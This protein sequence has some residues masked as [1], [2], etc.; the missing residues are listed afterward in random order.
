MTSRRHSLVTARVTPGGMRSHH[1]ADNMDETF[2]D[3]FIRNGG[4]KKMILIH[5]CTIFKR[6]ELVAIGQVWSDFEFATKPDH[7]GLSSMIRL[8][9]IKDRRKVLVRFIC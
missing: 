7:S 5:T 2:L 1:A 4:E 9:V 8:E 3:H 6:I